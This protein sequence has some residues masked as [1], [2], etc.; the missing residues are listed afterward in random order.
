MLAIYDP[1]QELHRPLTRLA[2][3]VFEPNLERAERVEALQ[4]T[5]SRMSISTTAPRDF[6]EAILKTVHDADYLDFLTTGYDI[7]KSMPGTGP[8]LRV[9]A[10][11][12][13]YM[14]RLPRNFIGRAGY[15]QAD[16]GCVILDGTWQAVRA[17]AMTAIEAATHVASGAPAAYALCRPPGH[18]AYKD[19]AGGFCYVNNTAL[20]AEVAR[21]KAGRV[22]ILDIDVH[23]GN[24]T[25]GIFYDRGDV[26]H[27][28]IHGDPADLYP[29]YAGYADERGQGAGE[30]AN[31]NLPMPLFSD[32]NAYRAAVENALAAIADFG[33]D[34]L[35]LALGLDAST[36][37]PFACMQVDRSGFARMGE[38]I[39]ATRLPTVIVQEGGYL[40]PELEF[41]FEAFLT[42]FMQRHL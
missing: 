8:E 18:H 25:Q 29:F 21:T 19:K 32:S 42:G 5:L 27:V 41:S 7:W 26:F 9:S 30:G 24:G 3:G 22:A 31:L 16:A 38:L 35:I 40:S 12:N 28:S 14:N 37:D 6:G 13:A 39:G 10:H 4:R 2:N 36:E 17:S 20:A 15:Y 34:I 1:R 33:A 23:H 11:P